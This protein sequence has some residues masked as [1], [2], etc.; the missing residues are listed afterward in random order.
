MKNFSKISGGIT[1]VIMMMIIS[2][3][4]ASISG[5]I[6]PPDNAVYY[7]DSIAGNDNNSGTSQTS[8][9][10]SLSNVNSR[11]FQPGDKILFNAGCTWNGNLALLGSG[12]SGSPIVID[13]YGNGNKPSLI[14]NGTA[15]IVSLSNLQYWEINNL[16]ISDTL[17]NARSSGIYLYNNNG[18]LNHI[19]IRN[20]EIHNFKGRS[21]IRITGN[22]RT[23]ISR[24]ND[25]RIEN[26]YIHDCIPSA[27]GCT[28]GIDMWTNGDEA[29][30]PSTNVH[31]GNNTVKNVSGDGIVLQHS[32]GA[33]VEYNLVNGC[34]STTRGSHAAIWCAFT[35]GAIFQYNEACNAK[36]PANNNDG[37][38]FDADLGANGTIFQYNYSHDNEGGFHLSMNRD[39]N[40]IIR[41]NISQNDKLRLFFEGFPSESCLI[42]NNIFYG[43]GTL[44]YLQNVHKNETH[45]GGTWYNNIFW[46][47]G[48]SY[49]I[50][51][52]GSNN[53]TWGYASGGIHVDPKLAKTGSGGV[54]INMKDPNRLTGYMLQSGSP[55]IN[56]GIIIPNNGFKDF[57]GNTL[58][59]ELPD[60][61]TM[62]FDK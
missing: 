14:G 4:A 22:N 46:S 7:V 55:C 16:D 11:T 36:K 26:N 35:N 24:F 45:F 37:M 53:I 31:I 28:H 58:Y 34:A 13:M 25:L 23:Q 48:A 62:E 15:N 20:C 52:S 44:H 38:A 17:S 32:D 1:L 40:E 42:Y 3:S 18:T 6:D 5:I 12:A 61:G 49:S 43:P 21:A 59:K 47:T 2:I 8:A 60:I 33:I 9:W 10:K 27:G 51:E 41:Y 30:G 39:K 56:A 29:F 54:G 50:P 19:Y 57:W